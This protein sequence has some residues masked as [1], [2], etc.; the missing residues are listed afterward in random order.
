[1][2]KPRGQIRHYYPKHFSLKRAILTLKFISVSEILT[3]WLEFFYNINVSTY[4]KILAGALLSQIK[5][6][7]KHQVFILNAMEVY[8]LN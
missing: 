4:I 3:F 8:L 5:E 7:N 1:M 2:L 6:T